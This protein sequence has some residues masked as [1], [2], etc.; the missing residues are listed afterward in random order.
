[1]SHGHIITQS[2]Y[3]HHHVIGSDNKCAIT[4]EPVTILKRR[5]DT[6]DN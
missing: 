4:N 3:N 5:W 2:S 1:M 6:D